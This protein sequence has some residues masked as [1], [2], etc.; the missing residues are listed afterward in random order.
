MS[1]H[2]HRFQETPR[3]AAYSELHNGR[4]PRTA[5]LRQMSLLDASPHVELAE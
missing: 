1:A 5:G 2:V 4:N 3:E